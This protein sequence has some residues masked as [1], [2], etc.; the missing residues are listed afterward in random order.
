LPPR[1]LL[2]A[3]LH[4]VSLSCL[5]LNLPLPLFGRV[6]LQCEIGRID[7]RAGKWTFVDAENVG[8]CEW[9]VAE[10]L[11]RACCFSQVSAL[12]SVL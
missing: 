7:T 11:P 1:R 2:T 5:E 9:A 8:T 4:A 10:W 12:Q 6:R 3:S